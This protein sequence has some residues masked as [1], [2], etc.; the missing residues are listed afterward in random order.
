[1]GKLYFYDILTDAGDQTLAY[2]L[3]QS[4]EGMEIDEAVGVIT[5]K[6]AFSQVG[7]HAVQLHVTGSGGMS[8]VQQFTVEV[9]LFQQCPARIA[10]D[11]NTESLDT[12]RA[13]RKKHLSASPFGMTLT[14]LYYAHAEEITGILKNRPALLLKTQ[15]VLQSILPL[16]E[17]DIVYGSEIV[18]TAK[19]LREI[20]DIMTEI[21]RESSPALANA[22]SFI[23][24]RL[25]SE[26]N[27]RDIG[28]AV[29]K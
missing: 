4:P 9:R 18:I 15:T 3:E 8:D 29:R 20:D 2:T 21:R 23:R 1:M 13:F 27:L 24:T 17:S 16:I 12:I 7:T 19:Q 5:W 11:N 14:C 10:A 28:I 26:K 25:M 6:P 22:V